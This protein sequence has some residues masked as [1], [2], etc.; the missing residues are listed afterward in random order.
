M[1]RH[2]PVVNLITF[3]AVRAN[4]HEHSLEYIINTLSHSKAKHDVLET[5]LKIKPDNNL[6]GNFSLTYLKTNFKQFC[7]F[8]K[9]QIFVY[10]QC[11]I[12]Y[13][14]VRNEHCCASN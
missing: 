4:I 1:K 14:L 12:S 11:I 5:L 2:H 9:Q 13:V 7:P 8:T 3:L 6:P 10:S